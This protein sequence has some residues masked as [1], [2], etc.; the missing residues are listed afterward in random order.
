MIFVVW[1]SVITFLGVVGMSVVVLAGSVEIFVAVL[2]FELVAE[3]FVLM[4]I[5]V[6]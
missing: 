3:V 6:V 1:N 5:I 4:T 2:G